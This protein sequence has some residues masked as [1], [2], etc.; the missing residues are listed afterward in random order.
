MDESQK[1]VNAALAQN[2]KEA[3]RLNLLLLKQNSKD[4]E[5]LNRLGR[6]YL[7]MGLKTKSQETYQKVLR[8]DKFNNI[9]A[10]SLEL[11][12]TLRV[13]RSA[14]ST[15]PSPQAPAFL[16]EP[17][18]TKNIA[19]TRLGD[20]KIISRLH[21]GD[22]VRIVAREHSVSIISQENEYLGRL[23]DDLASRLGN[24][25]KAGNTY[26]AWI[27]SIDLHHAHN[28]PC[29]KIFIKEITRV[30][31]FKNT[32][33]FPLTEKLSYAAFTPPDL[34]H[35]E[36]PNISTT[37]EDQTGDTPVFEDDD[38]PQLTEIP[39]AEE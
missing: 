36:K 5:A 37:E 1:A 19:L 22:Y 32:P 11:L 24:F 12:K 6:A 10:K 33:S 21:P 35:D 38:T 27:R 4:I 13:T 15:T 23:P 20:S 30:A 17:G 9:A 18:V 16:E 29:L 26:H 8:L 31:K 25:L 28:K 14:S 7:E 39:S 2:W 34:I 3:A